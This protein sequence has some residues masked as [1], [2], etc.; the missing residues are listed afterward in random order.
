V[1]ITINGFGRIGRNFLRTILL[2]NRALSHIQVAA[3]NIGPG[4]RESVAHLFK[5]DTLMGTYPGSVCL[6]NGDL[7]IDNHRITVLAEKDPA[8]IPWR[9][10]DIDWVVEASG[11]FTHA[12]DARKHIQAGAH[13]VL[14]TAP[15]QEED[16]AIVPGVNEEL[17]DKSKHTIVSLGSCTTNAFLTLLKALHDAFSITG[18]FMTTVHSYTNSQVLLDIEGPDLRR[19]RAAAL[20]IIPTETGASQV[21]AKVIPSLAT[22][23]KA[24][25]LRVP[26][27]KISLID[28]AFTAQ[29]PFSI[30]AIHEVLRDAH[31]NRMKGILDLTMEPLVSSDFSGNNYSVIVDGLLTDVNSGLGKVFGW[32]DNEWGYSERLKDFLLYTAQLS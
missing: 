1:R 3:I 30:N 29:K 26:V 32:Y 19:S 8:L 24:V 31:N 14:I 23:I 5:Y 27:A 25:S 28:F 15:A 13:R 20:N 10:L 9:N 6:E 11:H 7:L 17:F 21:L 16:I 18:G 4:K 22:S 12:R 2:D